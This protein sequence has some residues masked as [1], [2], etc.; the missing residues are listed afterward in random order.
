MPI[1]VS[2]LDGRFLKVFSSK[3]AVR[4]E[5]HIGVNT[6]DRALLTGESVRGYCFKYIT[7]LPLTGGGGGSQT[8]TPPCAD[9]D[10]SF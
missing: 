6:L 5:L 8:P 7:P 3:L 9:Y 10:L 4:K 1:M 2:D